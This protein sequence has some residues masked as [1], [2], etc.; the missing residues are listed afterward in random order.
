MKIE[1]ARNPYVGVVLISTA[2]A[3]GEPGSGTE[4]SGQTQ[5]EQVDEPSEPAELSAPDIDEGRYLDELDSSEWALICAWMVEVQGG[6]HTVA[7]GEGVSVT[8]DTVEVCMEQSE[9]PHCEVEL[10]VACVRAQA[11]DLC[12]DAPPACDD[13]YACVYGT[14]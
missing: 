8:V 5:V 12:A 13:F 4:P 11:D 3:C 2:V 7:C 9:F 14:R 1:P 10:L 6:P